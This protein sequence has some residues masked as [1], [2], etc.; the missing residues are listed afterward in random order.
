MPARFRLHPI[1]ARQ[2]D[3]ACRVVK[4]YAARHVRRSLL[5]GLSREAKP[6]TRANEKFHLSPAY[7]DESRAGQGHEIVDCRYRPHL[8]TALAQ[9]LRKYRSRRRILYAKVR[10]YYNRHG[11][12]AAGQLSVFHNWTE[13]SLQT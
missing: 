6:F 13:P 9:S 5:R 8:D 3:A 12:K 11:M 1:S 10:Q 7:S 4:L 2:V